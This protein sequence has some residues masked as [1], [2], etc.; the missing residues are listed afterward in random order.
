MKFYG[1]KYNDYKICLIKDTSSVLWHNDDIDNL[2]K[3]ELRPIPQA[4]I[5]TLQHE[6][7]SNLNDSEKAAWQNPGY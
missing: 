7:G 1:C 2:H 4:F 5:N 3:H 6:D